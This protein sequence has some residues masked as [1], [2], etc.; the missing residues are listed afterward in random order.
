[1]KKV[2]FELSDAVY[3]RWVAYKKKNGFEH[4]SGALFHLLY[5]LRYSEEDILN[6]LNFTAISLVEISGVATEEELERMTFV[7]HRLCEC[8]ACEAEKC[9]AH[10]DKKGTICVSRKRFTNMLQPGLFVAVGLLEMMATYLHEVLHNVYPD[11]PCDIKHENGFCSRLVQEKTNEI[12]IKGM[13]KIA[14][15]IAPVR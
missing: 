1:M 2:E 3:D 13:T 11:A 9:L 6:V 5:E 14:S 7:S 4:D 15:E 8:R 10:T 12:W